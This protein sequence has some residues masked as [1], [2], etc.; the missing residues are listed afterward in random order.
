[1]SR[2]AIFIA[3]IAAMAVFTLGPSSAS[4]DNGPHKLGQPSDTGACAGCHRTH[5]AS[6]S[7]LLRSATPVLCVTCHDGSGASTNVRD[8]VSTTGARGLKGGGFTTA[9]MDTNWDGTAA[10]APVTS[11]HT[12]DGTTAVTMWG[13]GAIGSGVG[14]VGATLSCTDC[15]DP[16]GNGNYRILRPTPTGSGAAT[17][18]SLRDET[19][20]TYTVRSAQ[21][22]YFGEVYF[23]ADWQP[24]EA[25]AQWC[26]LCHTRY[27]AL[28]AGGDS[29]PTK[30][31]S[32]DSIF[33]FR[34]TV[35]YDW[36]IDC[37]ACHGTSI[38]APDPLGLI[39]A[40]GSPGQSALAA[41]LFHE[42]ACQNC[43]VAHG[44]SANS[45]GLASNV[46]WPDGSATPAGHTRSSLLRVDN[47]G[48][49]LGC[50]GK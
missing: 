21:N 48:V 12:Y 37:E 4:A 31:N 3:A 32:G 25:F 7:N 47:R 43:H 18:V 35:R 30:T 8:G 16:H 11:S 28:R 38:T 26:G 9:L 40:P 6:A 15:H 20:K 42:P 29:S 50:H 24:I 33:A 22:K 41:G 1:M 39:T 34:H 19:T 49:C 5:T 2:L 10:S 46:E 36:D 13:N 45:A 44:T 17:A 14:R 27:D 23:G